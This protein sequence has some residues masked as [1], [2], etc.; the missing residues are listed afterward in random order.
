MQLSIQ[1]NFS[2]INLLWEQLNLFSEHILFLKLLNNDLISDDLDSLIQYIKLWLTWVNIYIFCVTF[3][4]LKFFKLSFINEVH[5]LNISDIPSTS[6][7][8][9]LLKSKDFKDLQP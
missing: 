2:Q 3:C 9:K 5:A 7:V 1:L 8:S 6:F 4:V